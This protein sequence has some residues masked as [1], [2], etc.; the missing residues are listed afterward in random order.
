MAYLY[1]FDETGHFVRYGNTVPQ[2]AL[3]LAFIE[4][5]EINPETAITIADVSMDIDG[6]D[7]SAFLGTKRIKVSG[8]NITRSKKWIP[9]ITPGSFYVT[10]TCT[11]GEAFTA[12]TPSW[13]QTEYVVPAPWEEITLRWEYSCAPLQ[14]KSDDV[15]GNE[16]SNPIVFEY[17][18]VVPYDYLVYKVS[19]TPIS[20]EATPVLFVTDD[21][22]LLEDAPEIEATVLD[23]ENGL[24]TTTHPAPEN[25]LLVMKYAVERL[26][27][28]LEGYYD[29]E[30]HMLDLNPLP[31]HYSRGTLPVANDVVDYT[32]AL[33]VNSEDEQVIGFGTVVPAFFASREFI[34]CGGV[35][36]YIE[37]LRC[38]IFD[39]EG[40]LVQTIENTG[41]TI[42][43]W[44]RADN[45][46]TFTTLRPD[47][48]LIARIYPRSPVV[49]E[50]ISI[51][52]TR[53]NGGGVRSTI[54]VAEFPEIEHYFDVSHT[55][56]LPSMEN[57]VVIIQVPSALFSKYGDK[58]IREEIEKTLPAGIVYLIERV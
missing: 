32:D 25:S 56:G 15:A 30:D 33:V 2:D 18:Q 41:G 53:V 27:I 3:G 28:P 57:G 9:S 51:Y 52:D 54:T 20:D 55:D 42:V 21:G 43:K 26:T 36:I 58:V 5:P 10:E 46:T 6:N 22:F 40:T 14:A 31:G 13:V 49:L 38:S 4:Y 23:K 29:T 17:E 39:T 48:K 34:D 47:L 37:P 8:I 1:R 35:Y 11:T 12:A 45:A 44:C 7:D 19:K 16:D 24:I 50:H